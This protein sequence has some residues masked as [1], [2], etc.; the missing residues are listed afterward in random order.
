MGGVLNGPIPD[1]YVALTP[2]LEGVEKSL[3]QI[4]GKRLEMTKML[5]DRANVD[6]TFSGSEF[7]S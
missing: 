3:F 4:A 1:P 6:K 5:T 2:K 7:M